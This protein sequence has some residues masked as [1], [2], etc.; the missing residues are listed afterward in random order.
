MDRPPGE[1]DDRRRSALTA[2]LVIA[3]GMV[4]ASLLD[5]EA[6][7]DLSTHEIVSLQ[8]DDRY[9]LLRQ[10]GSLYV[11]VPIVAILAI[12]DCRVARLAGLCATARGAW[13]AMRRAGLLFLVIAA[14][15]LA[16]ELL[17]VVVRRHR[18]CDCVGY[19]F[20]WFM[21]GPHETGLGL[22]SSH[23]AVAFAGA[24]AL[25][26]LYPPAGLV[27]IPLAAGCAFTRLM[28]GAHF[29]SDVYVGGV[30]GYLAARWLIT[31]RPD[32][33]TPAPA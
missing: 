6:L 7:V 8:A 30:L 31:A 15:G 25:N 13:A 9:Q 4:A 28:T 14:A 12:H 17:K 23:A 21:Q 5:H 2:T 16:A 32:G 33:A 10:F 1:P 29:L 3:L 18:P 24:F 11:W 20:D 27:V 19:E 26:R 22:A